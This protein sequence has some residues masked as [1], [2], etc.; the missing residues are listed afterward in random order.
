MSLG[1]PTVATDYGGNSAVIINGENGLLVPTNDSVAMANAIS[2]LLEDDALYAKLS[3]G[4][5]KVFNMRYRAE[6]M[7]RQ[8]EDVYTKLAKERRRG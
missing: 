7:T 6:I 1:K 8:I 3:A 2:T 5:T 4:A